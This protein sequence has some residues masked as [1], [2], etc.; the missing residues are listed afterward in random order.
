VSEAVG[1]AASPE[2]AVTPPEGEPEVESSPLAV[3][4]NRPFLLLWL[5]QL[6]TQVGGNM[7]VFGLTVIVAE[8]T[9][10]SSA[11]GL[12][13]LTFLV[14]P[15]LFSALAGV[16]VD[17]IDRRLVLVVTNLLR[18]AAFG[19]MFVLEQN[20]AALY[21]LNF[22]VSTVTVFFAP[23][24]AAMIPSLVPRSLLLAANSL[25]TF[26]L[27]AAF[28]IGFAV[29]GPL[30]VTVAGPQTLILVVAIF[31][32]VAAGFCFT[33][34]SSPPPLAGPD[35]GGTAV[36]AVRATFDQLA[37]GLRY[38]RSNPTIGWSLLY[39]GIA[40]GLIGILGTIGP[41]FAKDSLGLETK[42]VWVIVLPLGAG[43]VLG[44]LALNSYGR[45]LPRRRLIEAGLIMVGILV[46]LLS[47]AGPISRFL[48]GIS[49]RQPVVGISGTVSLI[50]VVV[51]LAFFAGIAYAFVA[52]P[53][54]TQLQEELPED[55]RGRVFGVLNMLV[56]VASILPIIIV[57]PISDIVGTTWVIV[58]VGLFIVVMGVGS[59]VARG[60]LRPEE[61][62]TR[63]DT[64]ANPPGAVDP[65]AVVAGSERHVAELEGSLPGHHGGGTGPVPAE[66]TAAGDAPLAT[67]DAPS[68][69]A[70]P[71]AAGG[72]APSGPAEPPAGSAG[73]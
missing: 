61:A 23:A 24:E 36:E 39:L 73:A 71:S 53:A 9:G 65:A 29:L 46:A 66:P 48:Q 33:L 41:K 31:Y 12:L 17:R 57:A 21:I 25:F 60:P 51:V 26:T 32:L 13:L 63:V 10:S 54:Q 67:G 28:A 8:S 40:A 30:V 19:A 56:S 49:D 1:A 64:T 37:E 58:V 38:I 14:P 35:A 52:I 55:V 45:Y 44:V 34:P 16:Y 47:A 5:S 42:D 72:D 22:V 18:A 69:P 68:G 27:N 4:R 59:I 11:V 2:R 20:L 7:V 6:A 43:V 15:V 62:A 70:E 50:A 3:L